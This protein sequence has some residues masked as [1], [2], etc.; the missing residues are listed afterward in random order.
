[1]ESDSDAE[2]ERE[3][4]ALEEGD[5]DREAEAEGERLEDGLREV[6]A[7]G[8]KEALGDP[9]AEAEGERE[10][11]G[12]VEPDCPA[13]WAGEV[14]YQSTPGLGPG[15]PSSYRKMLSASSRASLGRRDLSIRVITPRFQLLR[16]N[17]CGSGKL[18]L[19]PGWIFKGIRYCPHCVPERSTRLKGLAHVPLSF[20][21]FILDR[22]FSA[23]RIASS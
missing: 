7:L 18:R 21:I 17:N 2:G 23:S 10:A 22:A 15:W 3:A 14:P 5:S 1:M 12:E 4:E 11:L 6:E 20:S 9:E 16:V 8:D 13:P 19:R